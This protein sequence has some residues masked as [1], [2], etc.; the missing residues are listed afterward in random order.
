MI[1]LSTYRNWKGRSLYK[2]ELT[3]HIFKDKDRLYF[4]ITKQKSSSIIPAV[5]SKLSELGFVITDYQKGTAKKENSSHV[6]KIGKILNK[7]KCIALKNLFD[8]DRTRSGHSKDF[9]VVVCRHPYDIAGMGTGRGW[10]SCFDL[11]EGNFSTKVELEVANANLVAYLIEDT[12]R[13]IQRPTARFRLV[14]Y[15]E[16]RKSIWHRAPLVYGE[17]IPEFAQTID[18]WL[19]TINF[20]GAGL[21]ELEI[22]VHKDGAPSAVVRI[23]SMEHLNSLG[24]LMHVEFR[25]KALAEIAVMRE[26]PSTIKAAL[27]S[28][29]VDLDLIRVALKYIRTY[30]QLEVFA[31]SQYK[32]SLE[33]ELRLLMCRFP[34]YY[35]RF[36]FIM[37]NPRNYYEW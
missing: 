35:D 17:A 16:G 25:C 13:N 24:N 15:C 1:K 4:D 27:D 33:T 9:K 28:G 14:R 23:D 10:Q 31:S 5:E 19:S 20:S 22:P 11:V 36:N 8:N 32:D 30:A 37:D 26:E 7:A 3:E 18:S 34:Q 2:P 29:L 21:F 12:D 6:F